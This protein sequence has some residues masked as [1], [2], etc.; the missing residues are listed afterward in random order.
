MNDKRLRREAI[1]K[2][3]DLSSLLR[4]AAN[5]EDVKIQAASMKKAASEQAIKIYERKNMQPK[6]RCKY[7]PP[8]NKCEQ[9]QAQQT[10]KLARNAPFAGAIM[11]VPDLIAQHQVGHT[12]TVRRKY[13][14]RQPVNLKKEFELTMLGKKQSR[15]Q[16]KVR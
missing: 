2:T 9:P 8:P 11:L 15:R 7:R 12:P 5:K 13:I 6:S 10:E 4:H 3:Y 16:K 1:L 14:S